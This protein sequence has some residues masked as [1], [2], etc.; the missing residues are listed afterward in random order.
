MIAGDF[1][2]ILASN[3]KFSTSLAS[4]RRISCFHNC[5]DKCNLLD[6]G[7]NGPRFTWTNKR[8]DGLVM[9]RLDRV[10]CNPAWK[11]SF[12]EVNVIH[13]PMIAFDHSLILINTEPTLH[14][15]GTRPF[16]LETIWFNDP[17]FP[18][19]VH[20]SWTKFPQNVPLAIHDFT[21]RVTTWNRQVF[22][23]IFHRKRRL[24][25]RLNGIQ[26]A[27]S[28]R[29]C[30]A[31]LELEKELTLQYQNILHLEEEFW[32]LK[33][34]L[35]WTNLG[36]RN[37]TFF[38]LST[39]CRHHRS[40][41]WCR[42]NSEGSWCHSTSDIKNLLQN[43][44]VKLYTLERDSTLVLDSN[45]NLFSSLSAN[46]CS[47]LATPPT[48]A[49]IEAT[50]KSFQLLK[51]PGPDGFHPI[52]F[53]K[54]WNII[55]DSITD[56][57]QGIFTEKKIPPNLNSTLICLIPKV[58]SPETVHQFRPIGFCNTLYKTITKIL[59]LKLKPFLNDLIHL[60]QASFIP[61]RKASD[62]VIMVQEIIHSMLLS[63]S[64]IGYMA[65]KIDLEKAYDRLEWSFIRLTLQFFKFPSDWINL[66]MSCV[67][68]TTL[69]VL[70]NGERLTEFVPSRGIRQGNPL[71]PYLFIMCME[72][73][74][75]LIQ[76]KVE[77]GNWIGVK[78]ARTGPASTHLF[79]TDNLVLFAKAN[80]KSCQAINRALGKFCEISGQKVNLSKSSI[81]LPS[82]F[83]ISRAPLLER[84][85]GFKIS[86]SFGKYLGVPITT[87]GRNK[88]IYDFIVEKVR[89]KLVG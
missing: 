62:N 61:R 66:I 65:V 29:P 19:L 70:V 68:S 55:G 36:D 51:A 34:W 50:I 26:K 52:F 32:S 58:S 16:R 82:R 64:K 88:Q 49:D 44:F 30:L 22:G 48:R 38:H 24:L 79:F 42:K 53:Q 13:L 71:S 23:N 37:T 8:Q 18:N 69:S 46:T 20:D 41:I 33:S 63:H 11:H 74:A 77:G 28:F 10:L 14:N 45:P 7:F 9:E 60:F 73:L 59:V 4:Q 12:E 2:E 15:F 86:K 5:L 80:S 81:F 31:L 67:S 83:N 47:L 72:Y 21:N 17:S 87:D 43:H 85:L 39:I 3:E 57:I 76:V 89:T 27:L 25:A 78:P 54:F 40:R 35:Q 75:W 1:N 56:Y 6:L 84:E